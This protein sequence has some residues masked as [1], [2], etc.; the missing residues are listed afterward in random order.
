MTEMTKS[1]LSG[2]VAY[3]SMEAKVPCNT[4][5]V[6]KIVLKSLNKLKVEKPHTV[7]ENRCTGEGLFRARNAV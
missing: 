4:T 7:L 6:Q 2:V 3:R 5:I 1:P